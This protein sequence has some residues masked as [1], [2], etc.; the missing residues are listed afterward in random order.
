VCVGVTPNLNYLEKK[1]KKCLV[2][3][4][5]CLFSFGE[6]CDFD[7]VYRFVGNVLFSVCFFANFFFCLVSL[8]QFFVSLLQKQIHVCF[9]CVSLSHQT[10]EKEEKKTTFRI[11]VP[12]YGVCVRTACARRPPR[13]SHRVGLGALG[14]QRA[15][16][17]G[18]CAV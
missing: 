3:L 5:F 13:P 11:S 1:K 12:Q 15:C 18:R 6:D 17:C 14:E 10:R 4:L 9:L 7:E 8:V 16:V 2:F